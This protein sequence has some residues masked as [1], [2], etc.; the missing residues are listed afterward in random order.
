[1]SEDRAPRLT[2]VGVVAPAIV[3]AS[4]LGYLLLVVVGR[5]LGPD[6]F[7]VFAGLWGLLFLLS[8][9]LSPLE[10]ESGRAVAS[11]GGLD[12]PLRRGL[13][14]SALLFGGGAAVAMCVVGAATLERVFDGQAVLVAVLAASTF[15]IAWQFTVRG[16]MLGLRR[17]GA[18][19]AMVVLEAGLRMALVL[20]ALAAFTGVVA[21]TVAVA[22]GALAWLPWSGVL[23][24]AP[25]SRAPDPGAAPA[26]VPG[27]GTR[28][29]DV[30]WLV[31]AAGCTAALVTGF[32]AVVRVAVPD[33]GTAE[34]GVLLATLTITRIPLLAF[35]SVQGL[36]TPHLTRLV[37]VGGGA[38]RRFLVRLVAALLVVGVL[39]VVVAAWLGPWLL[40][41]LYGEGYAATAPEFAWLTA[42][43]VLLTVLLS[44]ASAL[45]ARRLHPLVAVTWVV[46]LAATLLG[47]RL[48]PGTGIERVEHA[49]VIGPVVGIAFA[50]WLLARSDSP[51][52]AG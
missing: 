23:R 4:V 15:L 9:L 17:P 10:Q 31:L 42:G 20:V 30:G 29:R 36:L 46:A 48:L 2:G 33:I 5:V 24:P 51:L 41:L 16:I 22:A 26:P 28:Q 39:A 8:G 27:A 3:V 19:A 12:D 34:L 11:A 37:A 49:L 1:M 7:G 18:Y 44:A 45:V 50:A 35:G 25:A 21:P 6:Q 40:R 32:P 38:D 43:A 14:R 13:V 52:G 47:L